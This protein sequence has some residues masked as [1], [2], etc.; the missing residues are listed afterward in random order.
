MQ[1]ML[2]I[3][4]RA[5]HHAGD[6]I[7]RKINK[8]PDLKVEV[9]AHN[10]FVS[11]VDREAE[12][13]IIEDLLKAYPGHGILAEESGPIEGQDEYRWI[14]DPLDGTTNYLHGFPHYAV[15]IACEHRGRMTHGVVYDPFKQELFAA[16]RGDGA[17]L[18]N[19]RIRVT[20]LKTVDG[21]LLATGFPFK[22]PDQLDEF[23]NLFSTFFSSACDIRRAGSAALDLAYVAAGRLDGYWESGL[24]S[25]DLA[26][27]ALIVRE[28][29]GL[30]TDY[31]G[32]GNFLDNG[33][34]VAGN[35]KIMADMLRKIQH[36]R[37]T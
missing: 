29:G 12:A 16:S 31:S 34:V 23:L 5:A 6:F 19:R 33:Q 28:A 17:T 8:L 10:D 2:N 18:N 35:P 26:A 4:I 15:S 21:A 3:A 37:E 7:V 20:G 11:E 14:I 25:W 13:R 9:K 27:G 22:N 32:D 24:N 1:P 36:Q 30:I